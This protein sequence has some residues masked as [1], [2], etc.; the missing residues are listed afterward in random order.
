MCLIAPSIR[1]HRATFNEG[2]LLGQVGNDLFNVMRS[3]GLAVL[4]NC[5]CSVFRGGKL[6]EVLAVPH[7]QWSHQLVWRN[8]LSILQTLRNGRK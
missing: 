3:C 4:C 8:V 1:C 2:V 6:V 7:A 5:A